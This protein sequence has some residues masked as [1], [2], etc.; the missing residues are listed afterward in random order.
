MND[1]GQNCKGRQCHFKTGRLG[2]PVGRKKA[3]LKVGGLSWLLLNNRGWGAGFSF[4]RRL[5]KP[6]LEEL[7]KGPL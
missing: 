7:Q 2:K 1:S 6:A 3:G 4:V 5:P